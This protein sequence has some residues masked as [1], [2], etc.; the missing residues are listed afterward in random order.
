MEFVCEVDDMLKVMGNVNL[1]ENGSG[2]WMDLPDDTSVNNDRY[3]TI[4]RIAYGASQS[5]KRYIE[6]VSSVN[7]C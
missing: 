6:T 3:M 5:G 2:I 7:D 4:R 1:M